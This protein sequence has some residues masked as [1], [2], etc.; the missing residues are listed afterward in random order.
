MACLPVSSA[1]L[2]PGDPAFFNE[3]MPL[4]NGTGII[5]FEVDTFTATFLSPDPIEDPNGAVGEFASTGRFI[6]TPEPDAVWMILLA[7]AFA[8][9]ALFAG[10]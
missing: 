5:R 4:T 2:H 8:P 9:A 10:N 7:A 6:V 1:G 3:V